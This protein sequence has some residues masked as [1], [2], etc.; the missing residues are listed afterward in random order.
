MWVVSSATPHYTS[1]ITTA[2]ASLCLGNIEQTLG[3]LRKKHTTTHN[4]AAAADDIYSTTTLTAPAAAAA[5]GGGPASAT[6]TVASLSIRYSKRQQHTLLTCLRRRRRPSPRTT[7]L[8]LWDSWRTSTRDRWLTLGKSAP[9][10]SAPASRRVS[11]SKRSSGSCV[12]L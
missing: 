1:T 6:R 10:S 12:S 3:L 5:A 2:G 7:P 8:H 11:K 4:N 9:R